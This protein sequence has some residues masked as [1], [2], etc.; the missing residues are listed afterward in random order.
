MGAYLS[1]HPSSKATTPGSAS[2]ANNTPP[3]APPC[4]FDRPR[5]STAQARRAGSQHGRSQSWVSRALRALVS[6]AIARIWEMC[7][8]SSSATGAVHQGWLRGRAASGIGGH[9]GKHRAFSWGWYL[10]SAARIRHECALTYH[11]SRP[12]PAM[13]AASS[14]TANNIPPA[15]PSCSF[16]R[17]RS[18][19][20]QDRR[21]G[22]QHG[23]SQRWAWRALCALI[24]KAT[25]RIWEMCAPSCI[26]RDQR[27]TR[28]SCGLCTPWRR[29]RHV[30]GRMPDWA[31][32]R[33]WRV[34]PGT[35]SNTAR[36]WMTAIR[37]AE[38][39]HGRCPGR[40]S[41]SSQLG[42]TAGVE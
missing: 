40:V 8:P 39:S 27:R 31:I 20:A 2:T 9:T 21:A 19:N 12:L 35:R 13:T 18:S 5:T 30:D 24:S 22:A 41:F 28:R 25:A 38:K 36:A 42:D 10:V 23:R 11:S 3:A 15:A 7:A 32:P 1:H 26:R 34:P 17:P 6:R 14:S 4:S 33:R 29:P 16:D 37:G